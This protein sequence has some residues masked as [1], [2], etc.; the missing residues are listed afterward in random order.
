MV[1]HDPST[2]RSGRAGCPA[3]ACARDLLPLPR[4]TPLRLAISPHRL[5][6]SAFPYSVGIP[7]QMSYAA[8]YPARTLHLFTL[9]LCP[10]GSSAGLGAALG[11]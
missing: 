5:L 9:W 2:D 1:A 6:L 10:S 7:E 4:G 11:R 8:Q 3:S